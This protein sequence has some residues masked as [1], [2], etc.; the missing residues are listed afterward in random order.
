MIVILS[1]FCVGAITGV[2]LTCL[3]VAG[4]DEE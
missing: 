2:L 3:L 1:V 4:R